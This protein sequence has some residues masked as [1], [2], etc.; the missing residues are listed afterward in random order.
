MKDY[1][2]PEVGA[3]KGQIELLKESI[4]W[5]DICNELDLWAE[6]VDKEGKTIAGHVMDNNLSSGAA[7][8]FLG[9]TEGRREAVDRFKIILDILLNKLEERENGSRRNEAG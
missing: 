9:Y 4:L 3:T 6:E 1:V 5:Q 8:T 2:E 7:L